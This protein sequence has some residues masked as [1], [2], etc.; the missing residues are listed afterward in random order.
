MT[1]MYTYEQ[2]LIDGY[3]HVRRKHDE[4]EH[5]LIDKDHTPL[6]DTLYNTPHT[7]LQFELSFVHLT[8][9]VA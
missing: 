5:R 3:V 4:N 7:P 9:S 2:R 6:Y 8:L 1:V